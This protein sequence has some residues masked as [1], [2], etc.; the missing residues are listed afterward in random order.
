MTVSTEKPT[1]CYLRGSFL[2]P[3][4]AQYLEPL[5]DE[6][7]LT[8]AYSRSHRF[9]VD[10]IRIPKAELGCVDYLNGWIPRAIGHRAIPNIFKFLG[11]EEI[12]LGLDRFLPQFDLI[13]SQE[14]TFYFSWQV[15]EKKRKHGYKMISV[16]C[17]LDPYWYQGHR[18]IAAR[19]RLV[20]QETD[21][22]IAR[23]HR[24]K[25]AL[26]GEGVEPERVR[27]IGHGVDLDRFHPGEPSEALRHKL[28]I[29][30]GRLVILFVGRLTW[31][32]G[33]YP[34]VDAFNL[35][36]QD[37]RVRR[38]DPLLLMVGDG[39]ER[40]RLQ[41]RVKLLGI[42]SSVRLV[43]KLP[44]H[45]IPDAHRLADIFVLPSISERYVVEQFGIVL[46]E[47]M[48]C[49]KPVLA[50]SSGAID[51]VVGDAGLL[52]P[53][54]DSYL[55]YHRLL[56]LVEDGA[57]RRELGERG[58]DRVREN[59]THQKI[60]EAIAAAYW[61]TLN[62]NAGLQPHRAPKAAEMSRDGD[63]VEM[64]GIARK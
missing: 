48:A 20:R 44:Y 60:S 51:E 57:L 19:A 47:A 7:E 15:A 46:I 4:E 62:G 8:A 35:L 40:V 21:L 16:Q 13:H 5:Q 42:E 53:A 55:L 64:T 58:L 50:A 25:M 2:N 1:I 59:F 36:L 31:P 30:P 12:L 63:R 6:F 33:V 29:E 9:D 37:P 49:G 32:K 38:L 61:D 34:L 17:M 10:S 24:A 23:S 43:G 11:Y 56:R 45:Q 3:F 22:F 28:G 18:N 26:I 39:N 41:E 14:E 52:V 54:N 27:V